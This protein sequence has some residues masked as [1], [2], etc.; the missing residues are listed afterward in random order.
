VKDSTDLTGNYKTGY[1]DSGF[2]AVQF[3]K[4]GYYTKTI[5]NVHLENGVQTILDVQLAR[6]FSGVPETNATEAMSI[7]SN[8]LR[9]ILTVDLNDQLLI[10]HPGLQLKI[11]DSAGRMIKRIENIQNPKLAIPVDYLARGV[12]FLQ[13]LSNEETLAIKKVILQ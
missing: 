12:Y 4:A 9:S 13:L 1:V 6:D 8:P 5:F 7:S 2:Y 11:L 10:S 3:S